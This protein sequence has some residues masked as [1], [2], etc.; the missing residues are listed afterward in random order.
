M[1]A[2]PKKDEK[3]QMPKNHMRGTRRERGEP[4][5]Y[6]QMKESWNI[7]ITPIAR[8]LIKDAAKKSNCSPSEFIERWAR[9]ELIEI[10]DTTKKEN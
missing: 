4:I 3:Y 8:S 9:K 2:K 1:A 5:M 10:I 7:K 6:D